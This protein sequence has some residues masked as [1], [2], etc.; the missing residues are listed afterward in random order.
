MK[1]LRTIRL[2]RCNLDYFSPK[3]LPHTLKTLKLAQN[4]LTH[5]PPTCKFGFKTEASDLHGL[6]LT[7]LDLSS[8]RF[9]EFPY[10]NIGEPT[11]GR[12]M[13][14]LIKL[15]LSRNKIS[16]IDPDADL[17][18]FGNLK[19]LDLSSNQFSEFPTCLKIVPLVTLRL[20]FNKIEEIPAEY[21]NSKTVIE[22]LKEFNV[23]NNPV[24]TLPPEIFDL[25]ELVSL[26]IAYTKVTEI[27][28]DI[29]KLENLQQL[30][31]HGSLLD[32]KMAAIADRGIKYVRRYFLKLEEKEA[33]AAQEIKGSVTSL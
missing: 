31:C 2:E 16:E 14:E 3:S 30:N 26:G 17:R 13:V 27:P 33:E 12:I 1:N 8:N 4:K 32:Q 6:K 5:L 20:I 19:T 10:K 25:R 24:S 7:T 22:N 23:S 11:K 29:M 9:R 15:D 28:R 21:L 18:T